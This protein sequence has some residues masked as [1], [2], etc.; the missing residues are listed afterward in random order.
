MMTASCPNDKKGCIAQT[1]T[2][3]INYLKGFDNMA[4]ETDVYRLYACGAISKLLEKNYLRDHWDWDVK[5]QK[6]TL[7]IQRQGAKPNTDS[8][9]DLLLIIYRSKDKT[10]VLISNN[11]GEKTEFQINR[12]NKGNLNDFYDVICDFAQKIR[13]NS[14]I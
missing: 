3:E 13:D 1:I 8:C 4:F 14:E 7:R 9:V 5:G 6:Y 2:L 10:I 11:T 12:T